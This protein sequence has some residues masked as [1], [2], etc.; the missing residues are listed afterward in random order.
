M[1]YAHGMLPGHNR[2]D[3]LEGRPSLKIT[4]HASAYTWSTFK[5]MK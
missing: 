4:M 5:G 1:G 2:T 3:L